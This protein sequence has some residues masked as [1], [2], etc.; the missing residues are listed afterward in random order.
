MCGA[1]AQPNVLTK[2]DKQVVT[3]YQ[4][5]ADRNYPF[6]KIL[7]D[8]SLPFTSN[9]LLYNFKDNHAYWVRFSII[10]PFRYPQEYYLSVFPFIDDAFYYYDNDVKKWQQISSGLGAN[11]HS[12]RFGYFPLTVDNNTKN[13]FYARINLSKLANFKDSTHA[14]LNLIKTAVVKQSDQRSY[15]F[16]IATLVIIFILFLYN[17][18]TWLVVKDKA[19][20]YY[21]LIVAG[22]MIYVT[23]INKLFN[24]LI[25]F[26][27]FQVLLSK[28]GYTYFYNVNAFLTD[29]GIVLVITGFI[30]F[31][32]NYLQT[33]MIL[34]AWDKV[35]KYINIIFATIVLF[36]SITTI[37]GIWYSFN[38]FSLPINIGVVVIMLLIIWVGIIAYKRKY[39]F[40]KYFLMANILPLL[41]VLL[42]AI[43]FIINPTSNDGGMLLPNLAIL[44]QTLTFAI[45]L[46][47]RINILKQD[48]GNEQL[49]AQS[50][51]NTLTKSEQS[52]TQKTVQLKEI[53]H[54]VKNNLQIINGLLFMQFKDNSDEKMKVQL[55][56]SQ[57]RIKSMALVHH[58]LYETDNTVHVYIK[59]YIKDLAGDILKTNTPSGKSIQLNIEENEAVNLSLNT[60]ISLGLIL[61]ELITNACKYAFANK[62]TGHINITINKKDT[63]YQLVVKDDGS[64]LTGDFHQKSSMGLRLVTN[65]SKQLGGGAK[66]ENNNGTLVTIN[67]VDA[68]AA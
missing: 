24:V 53:H 19:F 10:N 47:A 4:I 57:E 39:T 6:E 46:S 45:A 51:M 1:F 8:S 55:K 62:E 54:R 48:L 33:K 12:K 66:F 14:R 32:R 58:K 65:L 42:V 20:L 63:G 9:P 56:Q 25:P 50:L 64:G 2:A 31:T 7:S 30:Q 60:S 17:L 29:T 67:F 22:G 68:A 41:L 35:L 34:P 49:Q 16:W 52:N 11:D 28:E 5:L 44:S 40:G 37:T 18:Y 43:Y 36:T 13:I 15:I 21:L 59:E 27:H 38:Y 23:G 61:N 26:R 3:D